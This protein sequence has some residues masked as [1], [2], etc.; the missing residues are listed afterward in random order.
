MGRLNPDTQVLA[1]VAAAGVSDGYPDQVNIDLKDLAR[2]NGPC[3][4][5]LRTG[6]SALC[7]DIE[8]DPN[9]RPFREEAMRRGYHSSGGFPLKVGD[10]TVGILN[11]DAEVPGF[12][13]VEELSLLGHLTMDFSFALE[14]AAQEQE[15]RLIRNRLRETETRYKALFDN[16]PD[17]LFLISADTENGGQIL[18][19]NHLAAPMHGY[20]PED[21]LGRSIGDLIASNAA[22]LA[23]AR[24]RCITP[25]ERF[26][27]EDEHRRKDGTQFPVEVTAVGILVNGRSRV[28]AFDRDISLRRQAQEALQL[29]ERRFSRTGGNH[30]GCLLDHGS[31]QEADALRRSG[32][33]QGGGAYP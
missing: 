29:S 5:C 30:R 32:L 33:P 11:L 7:N 23:P 12:F 25:G 2:S 17:A 22:N 18:A 28:L 27:F 10:A 1:P 4:R 16:A 19:V 24:F 26:S 9:Y 8:N 15:K 20:R 13:D 31:G 3:G 6:Q 21:P 14:V